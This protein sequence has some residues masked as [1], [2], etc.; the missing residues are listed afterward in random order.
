M[1]AISVLSMLV[2]LQA[3]DKVHYVILQPLLA[4]IHIDPLDRRLLNPPA[5]QITSRPMPDIPPKARYWTRIY[6][7]LIVLYRPKRSALKKIKN[8]KRQSDSWKSRQN[9][10][11]KSAG[12]PKQSTNSHLTFIVCY[13]GVPPLLFITETANL[14]ERLFYLEFVQLFSLPDKK[15]IWQ[16]SRYPVG[17]G[18][19]GGARRKTRIE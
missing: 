7:Q 18:I 12:E 17:A 3:V 8:A 15:S 9:Y 14:L 1:A 2:R 11:W 13:R 4:V 5:S 19:C 16:V 10:R 6:K